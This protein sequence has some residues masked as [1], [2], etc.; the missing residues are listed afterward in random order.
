DGSEA[1]LALRTPNG[2]ALTADTALGIVA[3]V[4]A[5]H[6]PG[7]YYTPTQLMGADWVLSLPGVQLIETAPGS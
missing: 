5:T 2:Y 4:L 6:P 1:K 3:R 7:G